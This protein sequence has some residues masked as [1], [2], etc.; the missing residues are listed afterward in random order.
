ML[1]Q[2]ILYQVQR[3][4][5]CCQREGA[6]YHLPKTTYIFSSQH[7]SDWRISAYYSLVIVW[8]KRSCINNGL[9]LHYWIKRSKW[10][11][12]W[13]HIVG[14]FPWISMY[15]ESAILHFHFNISRAM[16]FKYSVSHLNAFQILKMD[17][18]AHPSSKRI[19]KSMYKFETKFD[20]DF[21]SSYWV[22]VN[23]MFYTKTAWWDAVISVPN[24]SAFRYSSDPSHSSFYYSAS[25][26]FSP[27]KLF[28]YN[29]RTV[30]FNF[31]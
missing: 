16:L 11:W 21:L 14:R 18:A 7:P 3:M 29:S 1:C 20:T 24:N 4:C 30:I 15:F 25:W 5:K 6:S 13:F 26:W 28:I 2:E 23:V 10:P 12:C 9:D 27:L 31:L 22:I 19:F 8:R 17:F